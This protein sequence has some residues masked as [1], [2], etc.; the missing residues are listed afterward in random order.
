M[1]KELDRYNLLNPQGEK[2][3][4]ENFL[5]EGSNLNDSPKYH[6]RRKTDIFN[7]YPN[8]RKMFLEYNSPHLQFK[9]DLFLI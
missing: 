7:N 5:T 3:H 1:K 6:K 2:K 8:E 4:F 9:G